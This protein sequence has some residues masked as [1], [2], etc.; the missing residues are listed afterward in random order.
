MRTNWKNKTALVTGSSSGIG[1]AIAQKLADEGLRVIL[2]A[3]RLE[4]LEEVAAKI[5]STGGLVVLYQSDLTRSE[6]RETLVNKI[7]DEVGIPEIL[8]NNAGL[9]WYGYFS[10]MPWQVAEELIALNIEASTHLTSLLLPKM[11]GL[12]TARIINIGSVAGKLPEQGIA[13]Y[14][15]TKAY[16]DTFT[17][18]VYRE[19][20]GTHTSISIL[21]A[22][23]VK[24]EFFDRA[25]DLPNGG[26]IPAERFAIS[27]DRVANSVWGLIQSPHRYSYVPFYLFF[28]PLLEVLF[29]WALDLVGPILLKMSERRH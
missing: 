29:S 23:P 27:S 16:L 28:S 8:I 20:R 10:Q 14:S 13:L 2:V 21:R 6:Q 15:A 7:I 26:R 5:R 9:G 11:L 22:G 18:S 1:A 25:S 19:L 17:K 12:P 4:K 3:R 24:T